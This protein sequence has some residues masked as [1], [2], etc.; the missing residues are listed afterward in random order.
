MCSVLIIHRGDTRVRGRSN[1]GLKSSNYWRRLISCQ[2]RQS[3]FLCRDSNSTDFY[4]TVFLDPEFLFQPWMICDCKVS[5]SLI[6]LNVCG[7]PST[8]AQAAKLKRL[9]VAKEKELAKSECRILEVLFCSCWPV[10]KHQNV[11]FLPLNFWKCCIILCQ[12]IVIVC[13]EAKACLLVTSAEWIGAAMMC[14]RLLA[15]LSFYSFFLLTVQEQDTKGTQSL[16]DKYGKFLLVTKVL[17]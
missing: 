3:T 16:Y 1:C 7:R 9:A 8:F 6:C 2:R 12:S 17:L 11:V 15:V 10:I 4:T 14:F 13:S 5:S